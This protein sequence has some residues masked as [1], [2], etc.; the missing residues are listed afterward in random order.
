ME[1]NYS[2]CYNCKIGL[3]SFGR[4]YC[5]KCEGIINQINSVSQN[6]LSDFMNSGLDYN[7]YSPPLIR[8]KKN[9]NIQEINVDNQVSDRYEDNKLL[10]YNE[11][12]NFNTINKV[13]EFFDFIDRLTVTKISTREQSKKNILYG[14]F[15]FMNYNF[16]YAIHG[17]DTN[18]GNFSSFLYKYKGEMRKPKKENIFEIMKNKKIYFVEKTKNFYYLGVIENSL[19]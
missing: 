12:I 8:S 18:I 15:G 10:R 1:G 16:S 9:K 2:N 13:N 11:S 7:D 6:N 4:V 17:E 14:F 5:Y 19:G 3:I